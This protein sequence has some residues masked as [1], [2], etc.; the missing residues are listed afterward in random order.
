[1][2]SQDAEY[3]RIGQILVRLISG[4]RARRWL[5]WHLVLWY[6]QGRE[7]LCTF[8]VGDGNVG[9]WPSFARC[10]LL[11]SHLQLVLANSKWV[12]GRDTVASDSVRRRN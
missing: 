4:S 7:F 6:K 11:R 5:V 2:R 1:M 8:F 9:M 10:M 3:E 12:C